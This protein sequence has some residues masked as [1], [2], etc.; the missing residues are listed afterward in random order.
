MRVSCPRGWK[1]KSKV[2]STTFES[3]VVNV[4][5]DICDSPDLCG[6][7]D[8]EYYDIS[9]EANKKF[10]QANARE[11]TLEGLIERRKASH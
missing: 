2:G 10:Q 7:E 9:R 8:C 6:I 1:R 4:C 5:G 11:H 3:D